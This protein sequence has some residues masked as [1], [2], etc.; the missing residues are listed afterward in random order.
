MQ[1]L[2]IRQYGGGLNHSDASFVLPSL[3]QSRR[4][5]LSREVC[6]RNQLTRTATEYVAVDGRRGSQDLSAMWDRYGGRRGPFLVDDLFS[7][8]VYCY[9]H[10]SASS[11]WM[12]VFV[13]LHPDQENIRKRID[14]KTYRSGKKNIM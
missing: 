14:G 1:L 11:T 2:N 13:D 9:A 7:R 4:R 6:R 8:T 5:A 10:K 12:T 3:E